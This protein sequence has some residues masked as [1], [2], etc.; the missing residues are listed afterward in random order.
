MRS[1]EESWYWYAIIVPILWRAKFVLSCVVKA[2]Y[3]LN[4]LLSTGLPSVLTRLSPES[5]SR[6]SASHA[7]LVFAFWIVLGLVAAYISFGPPRTPAGLDLLD[8]ATT[9]ELRL[10]GGVESEQA[11][12]LLE[13]VRRIEARELGLP[14]SLPEVVVL[15]SDSLTVDDPAYREKTEE[16]FGSLIALGEDVVAGGLNYYLT[17]DE[18]LV[19]LD[20]RTTLLPINVTGEPDEAIENIETIL[21]VT[22][23]F[24]GKDGFRV[25][26]GGEASIAFEGNELAES[27]LQK[28]ERFGIPVALIILLVIFGAAL[29]ALLPILLAIASIGVALG[30]VSLIGQIFEVSFFVSLMVT[31]IGLA[32]GIDY[33]LLIVSR[34]REELDRGASTLDAVGKAGATAG[35][36]VL[37]SGFTVV[38]ALCGMLII[39]ST[40]FQSLGLGAIIV[41]LVTLM[42]TFTFLPA[43]LALLGHRINWLR[44]P[45]VGRR[46]ASGSGDSGGWFW[47]AIT[48]VVTRFPVISLIM[49]GGAMIVAA[50]F[51]FQI[52][53]GVNGVDAYPEGSFTR[54]TF[55]TLEQEFPFGFG[56]VNPAEI[57]IVGDH[58]D[59][60][61]RGSVERLTSSLLA[62]SRFPFPPVLKEVPQAGLSVMYVAFAGVPSAPESLEA[63]RAIRDEHI[64]AAFA[65]V[66]AEVTVGGQS[67]VHTDFRRIVD[68]YTP[69]VFVF[70]LG[71]S[72]ILL[73]V[74]FRSLVIPLKA[75]VMNLLSVGASY[76][77]LVVVFQKG[78]GAELFGF[79]QTDV[80]DLWVPLFLFS[81]LFGLSMDYH[82]FLLSRIR[83]RYGQSGDNA[84]AV[85][86]GLRSTAGIITGAA[87]IMVVVFGA[88]AAGETILN[89]QVGFGLAV[90]VF[91]DATL[92][93][94]VLVP[95][96]ME[97]L[98]S[99]NWYLPPFLRWLPELQIEPPEEPRPTMGPT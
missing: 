74:V 78:V 13:E 19:S 40:F 89:Q 98:G 23:E 61:V 22:S 5:L 99:R 63:I 62:D 24:D 52:S 45:F 16:V 55:L 43:A 75:I 11:R 85:A 72:F 66:P 91:L 88:F 29:A 65:G 47:D 38:F 50:A 49:A 79:Q 56:V 97:V 25:L 26:I 94:S 58:N 27:D 17:G 35:R 64:P 21:H 33:S 70:V 7:L 34:Y 54:D 83:E 15:Q 4:S 32:I 18:S 42:A 80:I 95:A 86:Y 8:S 37:F 12:R 48:G 3:N 69:I 77:L 60:E 28:G 81:I 90:A 68:V 93:R 20:R 46:K 92:V 57:V 84:E 59:P 36:T 31:M 41:V 76:G 44:L 73:M 2:H 53:T 1:R 51:F 82:V 96:S 87:V 10:S 67:A 6:F 71:L 39:P 14:V 30:V 9:T